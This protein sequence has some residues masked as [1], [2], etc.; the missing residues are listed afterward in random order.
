MFKL[1]TFRSEAAFWPLAQ[2]E[3]ASARPRS[4]L[5]TLLAALPRLGA[6][7]LSE[8]RAQQAIGVLQ[9]L[10]ERMLRDIG[11][12]RDQIAH[13]CRRGRKA[14]LRSSDLHTDMARWS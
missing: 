4:F 11:L 1:A 14:V 10:D 7:L 8:L 6:A 13:A 3:A 12:E 2:P 5:S 9:G